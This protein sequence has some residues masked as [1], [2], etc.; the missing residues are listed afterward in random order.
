M[1]TLNSSSRSLPWLILLALLSAGCGWQHTMTFRSPSRRSAIEIWQKGIDNSFG[2]RV[3]LVSAR[4]RTLL[5]QVGGDSF[6]DF[7]HVYWSPDETKAGLLATGTKIF[8]LACDTRTGSEIPFE[9]IREDFRKS[10]R[11]TYHVPPGEDPIEW[12]PMLGAEFFKLHPEIR[13]SYH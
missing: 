6:I 12:A 10:I 13:L 5:Y 4:G 11:E 8:S 1:L 3:E 9:E 7:F 2:A